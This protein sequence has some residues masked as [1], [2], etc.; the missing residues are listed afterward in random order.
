MLRMKA[1]QVDALTAAARE[2]AERRI[3]ALLAEHY[4]PSEVWPGDEQ[5][6]RVVGAAI[7]KAD[8][9]DMPAERDAFKL[10]ALMLVFGDD[11]DWRESWAREIVA[12]RLGNAPIAEFLHREGVARI[13]AREAHERP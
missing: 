2:R 12:E 7:D 1:H 4:G 13:R 10:A 5:A 11:F 9:Y 8:H 6:R 3:F